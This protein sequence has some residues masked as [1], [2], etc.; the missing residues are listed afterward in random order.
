M[1]LKHKKTFK[2]KSKI[3]KLLNKTPQATTTSTQ[4]TPN[5]ATPTAITPKSATHSTRTS[6]LTVKP[7][8]TRSPKVR[9]TKTKAEEKI[10]RIRQNESTT[11]TRWVKL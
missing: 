8:V 10:K 6:P 5:F 4:T 1:V 11:P 7:K 9:L 2:K 3:P